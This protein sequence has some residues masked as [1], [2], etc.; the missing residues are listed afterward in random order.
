M[1]PPHVV[2]VQ[3]TIA[4]HTGHEIQ[5]PNAII[6]LRI[7]S[8]MPQYNGVKGQYEDASLSNVKFHTQ[9][10]FFALAYYAKMDRSFFQIEDCK[11]PTSLPFYFQK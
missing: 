10:P 4:L 7:F 1:P 5:H 11:C 9:M 3:Q 8:R 6:C 2:K